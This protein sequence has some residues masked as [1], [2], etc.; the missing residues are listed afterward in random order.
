MTR[1]QP[2]GKA[3]RITINFGIRQTF[4]TTDKLSLVPGLPGGVAEGVL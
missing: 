2:I 3:I 4:S 1:D